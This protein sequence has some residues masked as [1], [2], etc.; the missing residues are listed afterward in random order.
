MSHERSR[1]SKVKNLQGDS[2]S[3]V[4]LNFVT[5]RASPPSRTETPTAK[6]RAPAAG[7]MRCGASSAS[8]LNERR[9]IVVVAV[10]VG[11]VVIVVVVAMAVV[12]VVAVVVAVSR[13][14][15]RK[16]LAV[17]NTSVTPV[18][19]TPEHSSPFGAEPQQ[20]PVPA[21]VCRQGDPSVQGMHK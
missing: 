6:A 1:N 10:A 19:S 2:S 4:A 9:Y 11:V 18:K 3:G 14:N 21:T 17:E 13:F 20:C 8:S 15:A 7:M 16:A 5:T 12:V